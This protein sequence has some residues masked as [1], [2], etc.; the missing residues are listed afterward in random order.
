M[1]QNTDVRYLWHPGTTDTFSGYG[2]RIDKDRI[3]GL[4]MVDRP[5]IAPESYINY[6][7]ETFGEC[8]LY[9]MTTDGSRGV[10]CRMTIA[11]DSTQF[12]KDLGFHVNE[13]ILERF[14]P[15]LQN[16]PR[17]HFKMKY[18]PAHR[19]WL[20]EFYRGDLNRNAK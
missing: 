15:L 17:P 7:M 18:S 11:A 20:S 14:R 3:A 2:L 12:V 6:I 13:L 9:P 19:L 4:L 5:C 16:L 10:I 8:D 1:L